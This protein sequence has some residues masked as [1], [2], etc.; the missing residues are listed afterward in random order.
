MSLDLFSHDLYKNALLD[1]ALSE[2]KANRL[3]IISGYASAAMAFH[4]LDEL[5]RKECSVSIDLIYGMIRADGITRS[6][7]KGF[8]SLV[9]K[10]FR[11]CFSCS[12]LLSGEPVHAKVYIWCR[13]TEPVAAYAGSANYSQ[14]A[15]LNSKRR[16]V[17]VPCNPNNAYKFFSELRADTQSCL[18]VNIEEKGFFESSRQKEILQRS[19]E[20]EGISENAI[21]DK[22]S[23]YYGLEKAT[24]SLLDKKGEVPAH[25]GLNWGQRPEYKREPN[26]AYFS[27]RG[28]LKKSDF[29]PPRGIYFTVLTDDNQAIPCV[30]AQDDAKAIHTPYDN[31]LL[32]RYIRSRAN[33]PLGEKV[34][35]TLLERYGRTTVDFYKIDSENYYMDFSVKG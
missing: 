22:T 29:F 6:N 33:I 14:I 23:P 2:M 13:D 12:Y 8:Q 31:S 32:G 4:H 7:H 25:S 1:P 26:Q 28:D 19:R 10:S 11:N 35:R 27:V 21:S 34:T 16:E 30:R 15:F 24:I 5:R 17:L 3:L 20:V 9:Q 18:E